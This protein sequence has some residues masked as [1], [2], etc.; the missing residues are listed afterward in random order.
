MS[1][2][3]EKYRT[4]LSAVGFEQMAE[5]IPALGFIRVEPVAVRAW[6]HAHR[7]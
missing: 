5:E 6:D 4:M 3:H 7:S 2:W 1:A